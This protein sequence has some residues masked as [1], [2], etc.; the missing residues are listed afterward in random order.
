[1]ALAVATGDED[2]ASPVREKPN[3]R[4]Y[5]L[6]DT[7]RAHH[8]LGRGHDRQVI[9]AIRQAERTAPALTH[10]LFKPFEACPGCLRHKGIRSPDHPMWTARSDC[11]EA[12]PVRQ[13]A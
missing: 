5:H 9:A 4:A 7:A 8:Q 2:G 1:V 11:V 10:G 13:P 3:R 6:M 12:H